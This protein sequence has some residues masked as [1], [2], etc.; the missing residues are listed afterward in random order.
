MIKK[1][2]VREYNSKTKSGDADIWKSD[3]TIT[4][5]RKKVTKSY[6]DIINDEAYSF[7]GSKN[8]KKSSGKEV[9]KTYRKSGSQMGGF[10]LSKTKSTTSKSGKVKS[11]A[12]TKTSGNY[13][14]S[15][16]VVKNGVEKKYVAWKNGKI[17]IKRK[18]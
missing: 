8:K 10:T 14:D 17:S 11:R 15:K 2:K 12:V 5:K 18:N 13:R 6:T 16:K 4:G 1:K 9:N 7:S 3:K